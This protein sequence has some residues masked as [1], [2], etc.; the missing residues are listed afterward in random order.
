MYGTQGTGLGLS[1][2]RSI[3][4]LMSGRIEC[5]S[6][7]GRGTTFDVY[8]PIEPADVG[9]PDNGASYAGAS[10]AIS[11]MHILLCEDNQLNAEIA[12]TI[13]RERGEAVVDHAR[14]GEEGLRMFV[15]S[16]PGAYDAVLM[17]LRMP[18]MDG[19]EATRAIRALD[20]PDAKT[21]P[22]VAMTA[23]AFAEDVER[24]LDAGMN[25]HVAKPIDPGRLFAVLGALAGTRGR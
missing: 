11:G 24:C 21:V 9:R 20:R 6:E 16:R 1:I 14:D 3:V 15:G 19:L 2:V 8:L 10:G 12:E 4:D 23:D 5:D 13:L 22:I 17:D 7:L 25:D 18:V